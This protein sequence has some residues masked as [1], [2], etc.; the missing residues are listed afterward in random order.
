MA[1]YKNVFDVVALF[2]INTACAACKKCLWRVVARSSAHENHSLRKQVHG[3]HK[4]VSRHR[5]QAVGLDCMRLYG[6]VC[7][8]GAATES[9]L[10]PTGIWRG[11]E[12]L[13]GLAE[14]DAAPEASG[15]G[16]A[17]EADRAR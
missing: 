13:Q 17:E 5:T 15:P 3:L 12:A 8:P 9:T 2:N 16:H 4:R 14:S 11:G 10:P 6:A 7:G 1:I